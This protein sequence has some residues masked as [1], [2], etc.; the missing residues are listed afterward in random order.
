MAASQAPPAAN[1]PAQEASSNVEAKPPAKPKAR[2]LPRVKTPTV[3]QMEA[4]ECGAA[5]LGIILAYYRRIVPLEELR[6]ACGVS[7]DGSNAAN[8]LK[9]AR[10]YGLTAKGYFQE[11]ET[12]KGLRPPL[13]VFWNFA[14]FL[15][16]EGFA[17]DKVYLNDP[18]TGPRTITWDEFDASFTGVAI[19]CEPGPEFKPGGSKPNLLMGLYRRLVSSAPAVAYVVTAGLAL[20]ALGLVIPSFTRTFVDQILVT[21]QDW[22]VPLLVA[23]AVAVILRGLATALQ[24][25]YL[26]RLEAKLAV[27]M[28][29]GFFRHLLRLPVEFFMQRHAGDLNTRVAINDRVARLL[30]GDLGNALLNVIVIGFYALLMVQYDAV[31]ATL[32]VVI[33][34]VNFFALRYISRQRVDNS[35]R[36]LTDR[37]KLASVTVGGMQTIETIKATGAESDFFARWA[38]HG[39]KLLNSQARAAVVIQSL[40]ALPVLLMSLSTAAILTLGGFRVMEGVLSIGM[41]TAFQALMTSFLTP[42]NQ[43]VTLGGT[44]QDVEGDMNRL[45]DVF[46][47][48]TDPQVVADTSLDPTHAPK[49]A[50][51]LELRGVTFGYSRLA[52][53]LIEGLNLSLKPG[54]RVALVGGSGSGK[55]TVAKL[56]GGLYEP[57]EGEILFDGCPR[58]DVPRT[59]LTSS[60]AM[61]DQDIFLFEGTV[62]DNLTL[63]E[64]SIPE[65]DVVQAA[66]DAAIHA[67]IVSRPGGYDHMIE[68][69]G[70]NFSGGQRQRLEIAR[71]LAGSPTVLVLDEATSALDPLTEQAIDE[72]LRRRGCTCLIVAHRL[73]TIRDCDEIIVLERGKVVQRGSHDELIRV[74][75][76]YATLIGSEEYKKEGAQ[77]VL[78]RI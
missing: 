3:L 39:V 11:V 71:S 36:L 42:V 31:L 2:L 30:A 54:E 45:D 27:E 21:D 28:A 55:S 35:Q 15:V 57:W 74:E 69:M 25:H 67:E 75:G 7:R 49:L 37:G 32:G 72:A 23:M 33:A 9:A 63:W 59:V 44:L 76:A 48:S 26:L 17:K 5:S 47:Y 68:E 41:L 22:I 20:T 65:T 73:S 13:I 19:L 18:A 34:L 24:Q 10:S 50:G 4:V 52:P 1:P 46:R 64:A 61:V 8:L 66:K 77:S 78:E 70:R 40:T 53:P 38:G 56:V 60:L 14:H 58:A 16:V 29:G 62:R 51:Y 43:I 6:I 12:I